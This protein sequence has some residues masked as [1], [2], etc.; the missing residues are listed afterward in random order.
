MELQYVAQRN[1]LISRLDGPAR[2]EAQ[3]DLERHIVLQSGLIALGF[4][5]VASV[6]DGVYG[7]A[8]R[9]AIIE[10]QTRAAVKL[11]GFLSD[12]DASLLERSIQ[13]KSAQS[14]VSISPPVHT[15]GGAYPSDLVKHSEFRDGIRSRF[16]QQIYQSLL[17]MSQGPS[18][19]LK[20]I[21]NR[22]LVGSAC[23]PHLCTE[24]EIFIAFDVLDKVPYVAILLEGKSR[25]LT[26][27]LTDPWPSSLRSE[28]GAWQASLEG[29]LKYTQVGM[30]QTSSE[31][32]GLTPHQALEAASA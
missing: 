27:A 26:P 3:R 29:A 14:T 11:S 16:S 1:T 31:P 30:G 9:A 24:S 13:Q 17:D 25:V 12:D 15:L 23:V 4:L 18:S 22:W 20:L 10:F 5:P 8:T 28:I 6:A 21:Q 7:P 2:Q 19:G 32:R